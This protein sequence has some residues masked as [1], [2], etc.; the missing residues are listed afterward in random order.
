MGGGRIFISAP[1]QC[2]Q[3]TYI[4]Y[5]G[6]HGPMMDETYF[7][8][9]SERAFDLPPISDGPEC[10]ILSISIDAI[11]ELGSGENV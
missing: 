5:G 2:V 8:P 10:L 4:Q 11:L 1:V 6:D 9:K 7:A 3:C